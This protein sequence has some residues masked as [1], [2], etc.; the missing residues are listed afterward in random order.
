LSTI[1]ST[2]QSA[3]IFEDNGSVE[4]TFS[5]FYTGST[6]LAGDI[7]VPVYSTDYTLTVKATILKANNFASTYETTADHVLTINNPCVDDDYFDAV[8]LA[9]LPDFTYTLFT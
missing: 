1:A 4:R 7:A 9:S 3:V 2:G 6:D 5:Y 8:P